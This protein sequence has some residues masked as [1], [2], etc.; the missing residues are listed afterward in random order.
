M[1]LSTDVNN[2]LH[3]YV[4]SCIATADINPARLCGISLHVH[5]YFLTL[6]TQHYGYILTYIIM[7]MSTY[8]HAMHMYVMHHVIVQCIALASIMLL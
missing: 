6:G 4:C 8:I 3:V 2:D 7:C 1:H 5:S